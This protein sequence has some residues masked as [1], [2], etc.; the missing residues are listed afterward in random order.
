M[1]KTSMT[2]AA[3]QNKCKP[4]VEQIDVDGVGKI[5]VRSCPALQKSRRYAES[6]DSQGR[7]NAK[8]KE[9][10]YI[11]MIIDQ[12]M[13]DEDTP[14]F[15]DKDADEIGQWDSLYMESIVAAIGDWNRMQEGKVLGELSDTSESLEETTDSSLSA[16][17]V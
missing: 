8:A 10:Q 1:L 15:T 13:E 5:L 17:S 12:L 9:L 7:F 4:T 14:M 11:H 3:L 2:R 16:A 6:T